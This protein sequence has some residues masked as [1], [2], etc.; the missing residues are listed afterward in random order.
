M[1]TYEGYFEQDSKFISLAGIVP[2][3]RRSI[4]TVL[5]EPIQENKSSALDEIFQAINE[6]K[7]E[8]IPEFS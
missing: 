3:H 6:A 8:Y 1:Q 5:D 2:L 4:V 7:D